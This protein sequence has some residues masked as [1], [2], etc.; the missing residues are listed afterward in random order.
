VGRIYKVRQKKV[1]PQFTGHQPGALEYFTWK[2]LFPIAQIV[3][4]PLCILFKMMLPNGSN[5]NFRIINRHL[6]PAR[7]ASAIRLRGHII[8][9][10]KR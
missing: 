7:E 8:N 9:V 4:L 2:K 5:L 10:I 3:I 1:L 6:P